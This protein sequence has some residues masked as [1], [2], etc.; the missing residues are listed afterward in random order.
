MKEMKGFSPGL[1][2]LMSR[3]TQLVGSVEEHDFPDWQGE[4]VNGNKKAVIEIGV[5]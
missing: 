1:V 4:F 2:Q 3:E 5:R